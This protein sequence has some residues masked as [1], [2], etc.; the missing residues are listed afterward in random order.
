MAD[1]QKALTFVLKN[2]GGYVNDPLDSGGETKY[3]ISK[4]SYP[5]LDIPN[6]TKEQAAEIYRRDFWQPYKDFEEPIAIKVFDLAINMGHRRAAQIL[7]RGLRC[8]GAKHV[9]DDGIIG[10]ITRNAA[11]LANSDLLIIAIRSEAAG[12]YRQ[13]AAVN[14]NNQRFLRGWLNRAYL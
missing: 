8:L 3:G 5:H 10:A 13:L 6:L 1:F 9:V 12:I 2:E 7:Q 14:T 4:R 11:S